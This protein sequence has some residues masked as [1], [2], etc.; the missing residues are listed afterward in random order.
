M[1]LI[2]DLLGALVGSLL[3]SASNTVEDFA[4]YTSSGKYNS[5]REQGRS[6]AAN[7]SNDAL[8]KAVRDK[9]RSVGERVGYADEIKKR[10]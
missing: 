9:N 6:R 8:K 2:G 3:S 10:S 1:G 7:M 4:K 5:D